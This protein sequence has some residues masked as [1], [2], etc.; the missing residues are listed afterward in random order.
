MIDPNSFRVDD[1]SHEQ[2][3]VKAWRSFLALDSS[4][5]VVASFVEKWRAF[6]HLAKFKL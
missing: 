3:S 6:R 1:F 4:V 5:G 2:P